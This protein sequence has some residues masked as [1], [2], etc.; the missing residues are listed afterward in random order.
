MLCFGRKFLRNTD[1][2]IAPTVALTL[3]GLIA[4]GGVAFDYARL[5]TLDTELQQAADQA[6]LAAAT[7]LDGKAGAANRAVLAAQSLLQNRTYFG[8]DGGGPIIQ[9]GT[10]DVDANGNATRLRVTFYSSKPNAEADSNGYAAS[11]ANA[12]ATAKFVKVEVVGR[13]ARYAF[14]PIVGAFASG[15]IEAAATAGLGSAICKIPPLMMCNPQEGNGNLGFNVGAYK[16]IGIRLVEG[17]NGASWT[18]GNFGYLQTGL[19]PGA[20]VLEYAL[21]A[22]SPPGNCLAVDGVTTKPGENTSVTDAINTRFDIF[23]NGLTNDC[24]SGTCSP[25][26][27]VRK[28]VVRPAGSSNYGFKTGNDPWDLAAD[29]GRE[30]L[31]ADTGTYPSP[32]PTSMG[33]PR[34]KCHAVSTDGTCTNGRIGNANWDRDLYFYVNYGPPRGA[35]RLYDTADPAIPDD[36]WKTIASMVTYGQ[37]NGYITPS[38]NNLANITRFDVY[39][40]EIQ[41]DVLNTYTSHSSTQGQP[42]T[43]INYGRPQS[44]AGLPA[45]PNQMDRRLTSMAVVNC[46]QQNVQGQA[47]N[48]SVVKWVELFLVEPSIARPRTSAGDIYVEV[49]RET[50]AGGAAPTL[51]QVVRRDVP[52][53]VR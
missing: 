40:W 17:G 2:A 27:N 19:G 10:S 39:K 28:D 1:G 42:K 47:K 8:N 48:V 38:L 23:E 32:F 25:S 53:L 26:P 9:T 6:A 45:G 43:Y 35:S 44:S 37:A 4:A 30:Y 31:P 49:V 50:T 33:H 24:T 21:G 20:S 22:N 18:P 51:A 7:Q 5:A 46:I 15:I 52:Y 14:T 41:A 11:V 16:G 36:S 29:P 34:D 3:V 12:D 13:K